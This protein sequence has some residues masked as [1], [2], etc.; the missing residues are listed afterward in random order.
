ML[1]KNYSSQLLK[2]PCHTPLDTEG[3]YSF[4]YKGLTCYFDP[5]ILSSQSHTPQ[6]LDTLFNQQLKDLEKEIQIHQKF[7]LNTA[8][9]IKQIRQQYND[10]FFYNNYT[11]QKSAL[12]D[13]AKE[14]HRKTNTHVFEPSLVEPPS[15]PITEDVDTIPDF[16]FKKHSSLPDT[17][18]IS[19][20]SIRNLTGYSY[21]VQMPWH[22]TP[23]RI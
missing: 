23:E 7:K 21:T 2:T 6:E 22:T 19:T 13:G 11:Y 14:H 3:P 16:I 20:Q 9:S 17:I 18:G 12:L 15:T 10:L 5:D 8:A 1:I 4:Q